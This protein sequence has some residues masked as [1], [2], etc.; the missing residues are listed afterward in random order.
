M[1]ERNAKRTTTTTTMM[2]RMKATTTIPVV[3]LVFCLVSIGSSMATGN[4]D[5]SEMLVAPSPLPTSKPVLIRKRIRSTDIKWTFDFPGVPND[6][7]VK[8]DWQVDSSI[9]KEHVAEQKEDEIVDET[10]ATESDSFKATTHTMMLDEMSMKTES[11]FP[12]MPSVPTTVSPSTMPSREDLSTGSNYQPSVIPSMTPTGI[13]DQTNLP[14]LSVSVS[15]ASPS[16]PA[17]TSVPVGSV[18]PTT[19]GSKSSIDTLYPTTATATVSSRPSPAMGGNGNE[20]V[21]GSDGPSISMMPSFDTNGVKTRFPTHSPSGSSNYK[22][23]DSPEPTVTSTDGGDNDDEKSDS[24][25]TNSKMPS[26]TP[27]STPTRVGSTVAPYSTEPTMHNNDEN[28]TPSS[29]CNKD[30]AWNDRIVNLLTALS[31]SSSLLSLDPASSS[32]VDYYN[33]LDTPQQQALD[34]L[35][36]DIWLCSNPHS[37]AQLLQRFVLVLL[38][39]STGG[40]L[41]TRCSQDDTECSVAPVGSGLNKT[42]FLDRSVSD[43]EWAG[44]DCNATGIIHTIRFGESNR[45]HAQRDNRG[46]LVC[47]N[48]G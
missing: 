37:N 11:S 22:T 25:T 5:E 41:W 33:S 30:E 15:P 40:P 9:E 45:W 28:S 10:R 6:P 36:D 44:V 32:G 23:T 47:V 46:I 20:K 38:Y 48:G 2:K 39:Y 21:P 42:R 34:W 29:F 43:C 18:S 12:F 24:Q 1:N 4:V 26:W 27:T 35:L 3:G 17:Q 16:N 19:A 8:I 14:S 31:T 7:N 13:S